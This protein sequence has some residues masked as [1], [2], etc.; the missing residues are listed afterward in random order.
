VYGIA[1]FKVQVCSAY[2]DIDTNPVF[3]MSC[4]QGF[5]S[6]AC[7]LQLDARTGQENW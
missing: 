5:A 6:I 4:F 3:I 7:F 2:R 1:A